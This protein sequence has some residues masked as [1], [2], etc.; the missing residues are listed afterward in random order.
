MIASNPDYAEAHLNLGSLLASLKK[1]DE[2]IQHLSKAVE[3]N[4]KLAVAHLNLAA[5]YMETQQ[6]ARP[7]NITARPSR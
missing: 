2:A 5:A 6:W 7:K 3:L 1:H 4:P